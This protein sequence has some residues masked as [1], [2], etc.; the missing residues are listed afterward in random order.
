[1]VNRNLE[2]QCSFFKSSLLGPVRNGKTGRMFSTPPACVVF[3]CRPRLFCKARS[4]NLLSAQIIGR[5]LTLLQVPFFFFFLD[6]VSGGL[7]TCYV[8]E[9]D[10]KPG[11]LI[12][13]SLPLPSTGVTQYASAHPALGGTGDWIQDFVYGQQALY[14][15]RYNLSTSEST[16]KDQQY[17]DLVHS[18]IWDEY[19]MSVTIS[20]HS[21]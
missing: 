6:K 8:M 18:I 13:V 7:W 16:L 11:L 17:K 12:W 2:V 20:S 14:Q 9:G 5:H 21:S 1:M 15:S 4:F 3:L 19:M 10:L